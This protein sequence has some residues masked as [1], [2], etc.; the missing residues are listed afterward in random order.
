MWIGG[1][2]FFYPNDYVLALVL[3]NKGNLNNN[4]TRS[5]NCVRPTFYLNANAK[6]TSGDGLETNPYVIE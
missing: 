2:V 5:A 6:I 3:S 4:Y 1:I